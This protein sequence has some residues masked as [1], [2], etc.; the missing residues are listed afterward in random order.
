MNL[1]WRFSG[2]VLFS[3]TFHAL[4]IFALVYTYPGIKNR[5]VINLNKIKKQNYKNIKKDLI[6]N[7]LFNIEN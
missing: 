7:L 5:G 2:G 6:K 4:L 1:S 3:L